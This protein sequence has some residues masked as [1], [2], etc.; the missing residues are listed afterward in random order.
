MPMINVGS[1]ISKSSD[2]IK[3][4]IVPSLPQ[5]LLYLLVAV[6][7]ITFLNIRPIW[8]D[9]S[10]ALLLQ[11]QDFGGVISRQDEGINKIW[12]IFTQSNLLQIIFWALVGCIT[13]LLIWFIRSIFINLRNDV[14]ADEYVHPASYNRE[15]YWESVMAHKVLFGSSIVILIAYLYANIKVQPLLAG[16]TY[17]AIKNFQLLPST[18]QLIAVMVG[19]AFLLHIFVI[20]ARVTV[21]SW[22]F[23]Y[24]DL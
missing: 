9:F 12:Y 13:Y 3:K 7:L 23:I 14:V 24:K 22:R 16:V 15:G 10:Q 6:L 11:P 17:A 20:L 19:T 5:A 2:F 21:N 1:Y 18:L 8:N 4:L